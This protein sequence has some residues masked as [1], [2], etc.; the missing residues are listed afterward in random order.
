M[1]TTTFADR[2]SRAPV[3]RA[4]G[5]ILGRVARVLTVVA[6]VL[7]V[8]SAAAGLV[9]DD[10]YRDPEGLRHM[11]RGHDIVTLVVV[12]PLLGWS[13]RA[14]SRGHDRRRVVWLGVLAFATYNYGVYVL[15][16]AFND[17][18]LLHVGV[19]EASAVGLA[20]GLAATNH[21]D[22]ERPSRRSR[23]TAAALLAFLGVGLGAM[24][25]FNALRFALTGEAPSESELVL[26]MASIHLGYALDLLLIVPSYLAAAA[27][28]WRQ[29]PWGDVLAPVLLVGGLLQQLTY[30]SAL[31]FQDRAGVPGATAFDPGEPVVVLAYV[32]ALALL[33][34]RKEAD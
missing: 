14:A 34:R 18:F 4:K 12:V 24:W 19:L 2:T 28:L 31:L 23:R 20:C 9:D 27:L 30:I 33:L 6:G 13:V 8:V 29:A 7:M 26:P 11:L 15:G 10:L 17:V 3:G 16:S 5:E 22:V 21:R 25:V 32:V 1:T